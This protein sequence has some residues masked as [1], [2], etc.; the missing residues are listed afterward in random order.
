M[1]AGLP[2]YDLE[3]LRQATDAWWRGIAR[4]LRRHDFTNV[5]DTLDRGAFGD[6]FALW[7]SPDLLLAQTCGY[8]MTHDFAGNVRLVATPCYAAPHCVGPFYCSVVAVAEDSPATTLE[9]LRGGRVAVNGY[10]SQSGFNALRALVAPLA[11]DGGFF[12]EAIETGRHAASLRAVAEGAAEVCAVD[13]VS[14]ALWSRHMPEVVAGTRML[15]LTERAP[16]LPYVT[17]AGRSDG[18]VE[19]LQAALLEAAEDPATAEA[20][21][22]LMIGGFAL[23]PRNAYDRIDAMER[24]A[25][26]AGY[27]AL[28]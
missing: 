1:L 13:C 3:P 26:A 23:L 11:R 16:G 4:S 22:A 14:H 6:R 17:H 2:M 19:R 24:E 18:E 12:R 15:T 5:P 27:P 7:A 25:A 8:P 20:R 9:D 28:A 10:D 21:A